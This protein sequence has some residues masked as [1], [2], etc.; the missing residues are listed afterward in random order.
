MWDELAAAAW[1][2]PTLITKSET[3]YMTVELD[4]GAGYAE[5][6]DLD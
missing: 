4:R 2:D 6:V 1:I 5:Y 3:R